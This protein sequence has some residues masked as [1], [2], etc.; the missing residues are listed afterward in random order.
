MNSLAVFASVI[1]GEANHAWT[2]PAM[3]VVRDCFR[4][5]TET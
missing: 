3:P 4:Q 1:V 5:P 2:N